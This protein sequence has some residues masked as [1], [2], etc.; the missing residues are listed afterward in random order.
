MTTTTPSP[1]TLYR[2]GHS[3]GSDHRCFN[4]AIAW[5]AGEPHSAS[6]HCASP[7]I[8]QFG[9]AL[10]DRLD[11]ERRQLLRPF[12]LRSLGTAGDGRDP[13]RREMCAQWLREHLPDLLDRAGLTDAA[14]RVRE[15][16]DGLAEENVL[17]VLREV[18]SEA[19]AARD[20]ALTRLR[21]RVADE[22]RK[23]GLPAAVATPA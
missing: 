20:K 11:D 7:V 10:N 5:L 8:R 12:V 4:A 16:P 21:A 22:C 14:T 13:E 15:L 17:R 3:A 19:W 2:G 6:P 18:R 9:M 23:R 1:I